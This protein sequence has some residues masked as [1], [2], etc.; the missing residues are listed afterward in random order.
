LPRGRPAKG[1]KARGRPTKAADSVKSATLSIRLL[2]D[3]RSKLVVASYGS[4]LSEEVEKRLMDSFADDPIRKELGKFYQLLRTYLQTLAKRIGV[5]VHFEL[6]RHVEAL[7]VGFELI[8]LGAFKGTLREERIKQFWIHD[9]AKLR[10][11]GGSEAA[12]IAIDAFTTLTLAGLASIDPLAL[13]QWM[14]D[15]AEK[16]V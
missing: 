14:K 4:S 6:E 2:P 9:I 11:E 12:N 10:K 15:E 8:I 7:N 13:S 16:S 5:L 3:L 1:A